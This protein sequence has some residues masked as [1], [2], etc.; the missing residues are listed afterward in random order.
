[1]STQCCLYFYFPVCQ[2]HANYTYVN[3]CGIFCIVCNVVNILIYYTLAVQTHFYNYQY[4]V[5]AGV[6]EAMS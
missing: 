6:L 3:H 5:S 2:F 4:C 1:M